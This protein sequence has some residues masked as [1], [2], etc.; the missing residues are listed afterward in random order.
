MIPAIE[1]FPNPIEQSGEEW[2]DGLDESRQ[3]ELMGPE[4]HEAWKGG[5]FQ[6]NEMISKS[7]DTV[8][9]EMTTVTPLWQL[10]GAEPPNERGQ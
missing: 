2:F 6:L 7:E 10:L 9:G 1:G 8:Y 4:F 5:A 3:K